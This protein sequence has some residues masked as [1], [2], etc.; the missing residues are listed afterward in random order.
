VKHNANTSTTLAALSLHIK[1]K[2]CYQKSISLT[3]LDNV[4][5]FRGIL[6]FPIRAL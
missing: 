5:D 3:I 2:K 1:R 6:H 4:N